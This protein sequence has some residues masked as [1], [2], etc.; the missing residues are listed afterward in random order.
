M[1]ISGHR[2]VTDYLAFTDI[3]VSAKTADMIGF[4]RS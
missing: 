3:S 4:N 1:V 2:L